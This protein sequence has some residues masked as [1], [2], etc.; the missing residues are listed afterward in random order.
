M[1]P[2][3]PW[4]TPLPPGRAAG[5]CNVQMRPHRHFLAHYRCAHRAHGCGSPCS[6]W[7]L[8]ASTHRSCCTRACG[9][10]CHR[11][12]RPMGAICKCG[13]FDT[14]LHCVGVRIA[15][16]STAASVPAATSL[17]ARDCPAA[18]ARADAA[19]TCVRGRWA[20]CANAHDSTL[21][22]SVSV[23]ALSTGGGG[24]SG[25]AKML[26]S[27]HRSCCTRA[28]ERRCHWRARP[29][30]AMCERGQ[31][32]TFLRIFGVR[33]AHMGAAVPVAGP[34]CWRALV[35]PAAIARADAAATRARGWWVQCTNADNLTLFG[36]LWVCASRTWVRRPP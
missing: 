7:K 5:G 11:R 1:H 34:S 19:A 2:T 24:P 15:P 12:A 36:T 9:R 33:I 20:Q 23:S 26:A 35:G 16:M 14:F 25:G 22:G 21:L 6:G 32:D 13:H 17:R 4:R 8:L 30:N 31:F 10:R 29:A 27:I 28:C 18:P 3:I